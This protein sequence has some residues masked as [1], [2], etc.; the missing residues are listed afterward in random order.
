VDIARRR[1]VSGSILAM[2][3]AAAVAAL[4]FQTFWLSRG[5]VAAEAPLVCDSSCGPHMPWSPVLFPLAASSNI[6]RHNV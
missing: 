6:D 5:H 1:R 3:I 2:G 4:L